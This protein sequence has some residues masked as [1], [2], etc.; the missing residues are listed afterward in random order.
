MLMASILL[1]YY[2]IVNLILGYLMIFNLC[3]TKCVVYLSYEYKL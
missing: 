2:D 1:L 3:H